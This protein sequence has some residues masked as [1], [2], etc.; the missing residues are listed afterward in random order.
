MVLDKANP[1][2]VPYWA[3]PLEITIEVKRD[4]KIVGFELTRQLGEV[5]TK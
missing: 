2:G 5:D 1:M 4:N 3:K